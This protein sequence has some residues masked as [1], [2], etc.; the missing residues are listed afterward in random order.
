M[1]NYWLGGKDNFAADREAAERVLEIMPSMPLIARAVR[2]FLIDAVHRLAA[3]HG[4]TQFLDIGTGLPTADNT[5]DVA[6]RVEPRSRIV[7][8]DYDP[9]V[10][11][12]AQALLTSSPGGETDYIQADLRD[13]GTILK[14]AARTL[15]FGRPVA[16][17]LIAILHFIPDAEDPYAIVNRLMDAVP[18]GSY[19]VVCHGAS[20]IDP[21]A[22]AAMTRRYNGL[23]SA[24][25]VPRTRDQ[26]TRFFAGLDLLPPGVVPVTQWPLSGQVDTR[27]GALAGYCAIARKP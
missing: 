14:E 17:L 18:S 13:T 15:D 19:L 11:T 2:L 8:V 20:D 5:H 9:V 21:E 12:H 26:V 3:E 22:T 10:L 23:S 6:Q 24:T 27:T 4:V 7:Y 1:W 16:V 25:F